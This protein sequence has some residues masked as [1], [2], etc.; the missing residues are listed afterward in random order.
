MEMSERLED[1]T[2][3]PKPAPAMRESQPAPA[4]PPFRAEKLL[5]LHH[6]VHGHLAAL[7]RDG[8]WPPG[9]ALPGEPALCAHYGVSRGTL[10]HALQELA[11]AGLIE[12]HQ[13]RGSFV[14]GPKREG[15]IAG[16]YRRF[17]AEGPPLDSG[18]QVI[19][20]R[21]APAP[22]EVARILALPRGG[23]AWRMERLRT[24]QGEKAA[25]QTSWLPAG[26]C[27]EF[28]R[29]QLAKRHLVDILRERWGVEFSHADEYIEPTVADAA[30]AARLGI[31][32]GTPMF[33]LERMTYLPNGRVGEY[34]RAVMRGDIYRYRVE[35]R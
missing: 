8:A 4:L 5:P 23:L 7:I 12:R 21:R 22:A 9:E 10:R 13:G 17:R 19:S 6:Q 27:P 28:D 11:R 20:L 16:D 3:R 33:G 30:I 26:L 24:L 34:R 18:C 15:A 25:L 35:L 2:S 32:Q 31:A 1:M 29:A 14:R